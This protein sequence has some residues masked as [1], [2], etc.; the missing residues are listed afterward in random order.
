MRPDSPS[1][2]ITRNKSA[3]L[4]SRQHRCTSLAGADAIDAIKDNGGPFTGAI[5]WNVHG[6]R[7]RLS[8]RES[9]ALAA[10]P[11]EQASDLFRRQHVIY[12]TSL[13]GIQRHGLSD[14][15]VGCLSDRDAASY[16]D[17]L[18]ATPSESTPDIMT[19][20]EVPGHWSAINK[21]R[22][23]IGPAFGFAHL[24]EFESI[25][26]KSYVGSGPMRETVFGL[27]IEWEISLT[28]IFVGRENF[29]GGASGVHCGRD[30]HK[31][32]FRITRQAI[33][34]AA[35]GSCPPTGPPMHMVGKAPSSG[36]LLLRSSLGRRIG[37]HAEFF[38][39]S[40]GPNW[41]GVTVGGDDAPARA[42]LSNRRGSRSC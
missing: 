9:V 8:G 2:I 27:G 38:F 33:K 24:I 23:H 31:T 3:C 17:V 41:N 35:A 30:D 11:A 25:A 21:D 40:Y 15:T 32:A 39:I 13:N 6:P 12:L 22:D 19:A 7:V 4:S 36:P 10:D 5:S 26:T 42:P 29:P 18:A 1:R 14:R 20:T 16:F 28:G 34:E 37:T